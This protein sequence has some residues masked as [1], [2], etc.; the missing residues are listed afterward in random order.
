MRDSHEQAAAPVPVRVHAGQLSRGDVVA[1]AE[2]TVDQRLHAEG[3]LLRVY[4]E[5]WKRGSEESLG[6]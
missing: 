5:E 2:P 4:R 1:A 6:I 3:G